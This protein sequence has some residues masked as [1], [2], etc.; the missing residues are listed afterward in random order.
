LYSCHPE[1]SHRKTGT[2]TSIFIYLYLLSVIF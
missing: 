2:C 1:N